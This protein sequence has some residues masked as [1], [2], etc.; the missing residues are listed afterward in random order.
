MDE[1]DNAQAAQANEL[2]RLLSAHAHALQRG[3]AASE[4]EDCGAPIPAARR[5]VAPG[6]T[7]C[8]QCQTRFERRAKE[9][10]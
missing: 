1:I 2:R 4:C 5:L 8:V 10:G 7:R 3:E 6:C 9:R